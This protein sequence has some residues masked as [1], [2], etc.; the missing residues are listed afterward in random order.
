MW[1]RRRGVRRA[2][3]WRGRRVRGEASAAFVPERPVLSGCWQNAGVH[4]GRGSQCSEIWRP[5]SHLTGPSCCQE[6]FVFLKGFD[7]IPLSCFETH[8]NGPLGLGDF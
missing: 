5:V 4:P 1:G 7:L 2:R 8:S 6:A 3:V